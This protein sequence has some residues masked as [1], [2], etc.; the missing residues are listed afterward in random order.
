M[1]RLIPVLMFSWNCIFG[2]ITKLCLKNFNLAK[3]QQEEEAPYVESYIHIW[4]RGA[5]LVYWLSLFLHENVY[6]V[7]KVASLQAVSWGL[8]T[9]VPVIAPPFVS[10]RV[11]HCLKLDNCNPPICGVLREE[12]NQSA[13]NLVSREGAVWVDLLLVENTRTDKAEG[14]GTGLEFCGNPTHSLFYCQNAVNWPRRNSLHVS[15]FIF[16]D[17]SILDGIFLHSIHVFICFV[18]WLASRAFGIFNVSHIAF[19][20]RRLLKHPCPSHCPFLESYF[21]H[22]KSFR[23]IFPRQNLRIA[24]WTWHTFTWQDTALLS[25]MV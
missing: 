15:N 11:V 16:S 19:E 2:L 12:I 4:L 13:L 21:H 25:H 8:Y 14:I 9:V 1:E 7:I 23:N 22:F 10:F 18:V 3:I 5:V 17:S 24:N 20:R 6:L